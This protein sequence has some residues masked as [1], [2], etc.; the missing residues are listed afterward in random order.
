MIK[1]KKSISFI[2]LLMLLICSFSRGVI[3]TGVD[4][5]N[6][7]DEKECVTT[8]EISEEVSEDV[9]ISDECE[10]TTVSEKETTPTSEIETTM[11]SETEAITGSEIETATVTEKETDSEKD[12]IEANEEET[13][14]DEKSDDDVEEYHIEYRIVSE[15]NNRYNVEVTIENYDIESI[16][17][18]MVEFYS[19]DNIV[20]V[21]DAEIYS[22][23]EDCYRI[24]NAGWNA[25]IKKG[26]KITFGYI[27]EFK[28]KI[29]EPE[30][31]ELLRFQQDVKN[32]SYDIEYI[33][34]SAWETGY[35]M[36]VII[37]NKSDEKIEDW[38]LSFLLKLN[39]KN[40]W[41][42]ELIEHDSDE[43]VLYNGNN[44]A[45]IESGKSI[46]FGM[47]VETTNS[48]ILYPDEVVLT[49]R[50]VNL[51]DENEQYIN[52][53]YE[54]YGIDPDIKDNDEDGLPDLIEMLELSLDPS[55][56][57][58]DEDGILDV[59]ED[60]DEDGLCNLLEIEKESNPTVSDSD[61]DGLLDGEE[62]FKYSTDL[63]DE[64]SDDDGL[65]DYEE[66]QLGTDPL[67]E[68][69]NE[70]ELDSERYFVQ[71]LSDDNIELDEDENL[72]MPSVEMEMKGYTG[73]YVAIS[74]AELDTYLNNRAIL[75]VPILFQ[76]QGEEITK[77]TKLS[78][79]ISSLIKRK[80]YDESN[81]KDIA[82]CKLDGYVEDVDEDIK[83]DDNIE[84]LEECYEVC[85]DESILYYDDDE[86]T[87]VVPVLENY[88][89]EP[90]E[91]SLDL[92]EGI[93]SADIED[94]GIYMLMN[95]KELL[96]S[97]GLNLFD[98]KELK[99]NL[100]KG[101]ADIVFVV[102][103]TGSMSSV[104]K[105]TANSIIEFVDDLENNYNVQTNY[106][107]IEYRDVEVDGND[108]T[109]VHKNGFSNW[110][111]D[112]EL[113]SEEI[114][115]LLANGGGDEPESLV[116]ALGM[117]ANLDYRENVDK[118]VVI[119][120]D[121]SCKVN[122]NYG[123]NSL[124]EVIDELNSNN[125]VTSIV[126]KT[127]LKDKY[128]CV[129]KNGGIVGDISKN[130]ADELKKL[131]DLIANQSE[132]G[133]WYLLD[134][135]EYIKLDKKYDELGDMDT[136][137]DGLTDVEELG[138]SRDMDLSLFANNLLIRYG[139][140]IDST[141]KSEIEKNMAMGL[142]RVPMY[143][144]RSNPRLKDTDLDGI[145]DGNDREPKK[146]SKE[147]IFTIKMQ[148]LATVFLISYLRK[149]LLDIMFRII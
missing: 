140:L 71:M 36:D 135:Y 33:V 136:D 27:A 114:R 110:Y 74:N 31:F 92:K 147:L 2:V 60:F 17:N 11:D 139:S 137:G 70:K 81:L 39:I 6:A 52:A 119:I 10:L 142:L 87:E 38:Q 106:S 125:V 29:D 121:A 133:A 24:K 18:W 41:N 113:F 138:S 62:Y 15:W 5:G 75:G 69:T 45:N 21:W 64:D 50:K 105:N 83:F 3:A 126:T 118:F 127:A 141:T 102:D 109:K 25:E 149:P 23:E 48:E 86:G 37:H 124:E 43:Y 54:Y 80:Q 104:I 97:V 72:L 112:P 88:S 28:E 99:P 115:S 130:F 34:T 146:V 82:V 20:S 16:R 13:V 76:N 103:T 7:L 93:I 35:I 42:A 89:F 78:F 40:I 73:S 107:L 145:L 51:L 134:T 132:D 32:S 148:K 8:S 67:K 47:E 1:V 129:T 58:S 91:T 12:D 63:Q 44:N 123:Y 117:A 55:K 96:K 4:E 143:G 61:E 79:D 84:D 49:D 56:K 144:A 111:T 100:T 120:T 98:L 95:E 85:D 30:E 65:T 128:S 9:I 94:S 101:Q 116:E 68:K 53:L 22:N 46:S 19:E 14:V 26:E 122:N 66:V 57:D 108:T 131:I 90:L 77:E 59:D